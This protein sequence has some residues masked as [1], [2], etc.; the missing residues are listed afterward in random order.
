M[1]IYFFIE[2]SLFIIFSHFYIHMPMVIT[3]EI[4]HIS[5]RKLYNIYNL[6]NGSQTRVEFPAR[7][8][9]ILRVIPVNLRVIPVN[10]RV[11]DLFCYIYVCQVV[12]LYVNLTAIVMH[13]QIRNI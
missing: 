10:L 13:S 8:V 1:K 4:N 5:Q 2:I 12:K 9:I 6:A 3:S 7:S 11:Y